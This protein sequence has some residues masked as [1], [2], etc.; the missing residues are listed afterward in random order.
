[1]H[2]YWIRQVTGRWLLGERVVAQ[3]DRNGF[4]GNRT[5]GRVVSGKSVHQILRVRKIRI[6]V[7]TDV[8]KIRKL[9]GWFP[10]NPDIFQITPHICSKYITIIS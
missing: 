9:V 3:M 4:V 5:V 10:E 8:R 2:L 6:C 1:M 7:V